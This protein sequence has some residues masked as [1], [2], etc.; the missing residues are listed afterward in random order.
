M[1]LINTFI[2]WTWLLF[3]SLVIPITLPAGGG[4]KSI[5]QHRENNIK[6]PLIALKEFNLLASASDDSSILTRLKAGTPV[7]VLKVWNST[8]NGQWLLVNV[9]S[10]NYNQLF[11]KRGWVQIDTFG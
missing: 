8:N 11:D 10:Q 3:V 6:A 1:N 4:Q 7:K 2:L 5:I 9:I